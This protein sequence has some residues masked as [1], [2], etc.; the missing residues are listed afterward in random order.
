MA[1]RRDDSK[2]IPPVISLQEGKQR[3]EVM[4]AKG[5]A[6]LANRPLVESA[7]QTWANTTADYIKQT[8]GSESAHIGT[9]WGTPRIRFGD[10]DYVGGYEQEDA[11]QLQERLQVLDSLIDQINTDLQFAKPTRRET[12]SESERHKIFLVHGHEYPAL[13]EVARFLEK[14]RQ[15]VIVLREQPN[16]GRTVIEKFENYADVGF[17]VVLLTPDDVGGPRPVTSPNKLRSRARQNVIFELGY[18]IG[19]LGRL[20]VCALYVEGVEIPSDY[21]GVLYTKFDAAGA[22]RLELAKELKAAGMPVDMNLALRSE[23]AP[24]LAKKLAFVYP[25]TPFWISEGEGGTLILPAVLMCFMR[26]RLRILYDI[27][28]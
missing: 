22:W 1:K 27:S 15:E 19:R 17:A 24:P 10:A 12:A 16:Q 9:F 18:F 28:N 21:G 5:Q 6:M 8:F 2:A 7:I 20:K 13:H 14:L 4:R 26:A 23:D 3:L 11:Q 25:H